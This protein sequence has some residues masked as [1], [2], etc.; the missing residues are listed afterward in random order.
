MLEAAGKF[1]Q[2]LNIAEL[3]AAVRLGALGKVGI[4][5]KHMKKKQRHCLTLKEH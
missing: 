1:K 3:Y 2:L 4:C 5:Y